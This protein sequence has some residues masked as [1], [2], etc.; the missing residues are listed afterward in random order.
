VFRRGLQ[1]NFTTGASAFATLLLRVFGMFATL[2]RGDY[3]FLR[4]DKKV[5]LKM[6]GQVI[7]EC[8]KNSFDI[9]DS[10]FAD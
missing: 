8:C 10:L 3:P 6:A 1:F 5:Y 4:W 2:N 9:V 7:L